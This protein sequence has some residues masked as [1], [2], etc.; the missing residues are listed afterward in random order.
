MEHPRDVTLATTFD[1]RLL[2]PQGSKRFLRLTLR[3]PRQT[4]EWTRKPLNLAF[5]LDRSGSMAGD[6]LN[7]VKKAVS[8]GL[9]QLRPDDCAAVVVYDDQVQILSASTR[10]TGEAKAAIGLAL[11]RVHEGGSTALGEGWLEGCRLA[12]SMG[13][14][15]DSRWLTRSLLLT[16]GLANVGITDPRELTGHASQLRRHGVTT[17]TF[18][19]GAD[20]DEQLLSSLA[21]AGG[22]NFYFIERAR[23]IPDFFA[24]ELGELLTVVAEETRVT[25]T[26]PAGASAELLND[27]PVTLDGATPGAKTLT[28]E[29]GNLS[30]EEEKVLLFELTVSSG[31]VG[32]ELPCTL[33]LCYRRSNDGAEE[34]ASAPAL[35]L[36][37]A[38]VAD[39]EAEEPDLSVIEAAGRLQAARAKRDAWEHMNAGR[40]DAARTVLHGAMQAFAAPAMAAAAG[41]LAADAAEL[42]SLAE[43]A[44][45]G[46]DSVT[47][48]TTLY[49]SQ[50]AR[51]SRRDYGKQS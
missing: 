33:G 6:K 19:V 37:Y 49:S 31:T 38:T 46:W 27:Y 21:E 10:M 15:L 40:H 9:Q 17:S 4:R 3:A 18:G 51:K 5:I 16:D 36:R 20:F 25:L 44:P 22:G 47:R 32:A 14:E 42:Q 34:T 41:A 7:L 43:R 8:F 35:T 48:K 28:V 24:G 23:Q 45:G 29:V 50:I 13:T 1:R 30:A 39:A 2:P 11:A 12:A 26:L